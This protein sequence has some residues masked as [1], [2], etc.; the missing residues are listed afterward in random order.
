LSALFKQGLFR[1]YSWL[2][3]AAV[4]VLILLGGFVRSTGSGMGCPDWPKCFGQYIPPTSLEELPADYQHTFSEGRIKK[5]KKFAGLLSAF[6]LKQ[7]SEALLSDPNLYEPEAFNPLKT[8][9]EYINRL[10]GAITGLLALLTL[11]TAVKW[12]TKDKK[13]AIAAILGVL[14]I[15]FNAWMGSVLV[16]TNL[17][18]W[19]ISLHYL[20]AYLA[21]FILMYGAYRSKP[22]LDTMFIPDQYKLFILSGW[23]LCFIQIYSGTG[24]RAVSDYLVQQNIL[25]TGGELNLEGLG[26]SFIWHR[27]LAFLLGLELFILF[28]KSK[29]LY[30]MQAVLTKSLLFS[31]VLIGL[32]VV[33]GSLNL[34][35]NFPLIPQV[36]HIFLAG[37]LF[38]VLSYLLLASFVRAHLS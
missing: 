24:L 16:A 13:A 38:G 36:L 6:G 19:V 14:L 37:I 7:Q 31:L 4:F 8:W 33:S 1:S 28:T 22:L 11:I 9:I 25:M 18:S 29:R 15:F 10:W 35:F 30:G 23:M 27:L 17:T 12:Y 20:L 3:V 2:T 21:V 34:L 5:A 26:Q 32:Q